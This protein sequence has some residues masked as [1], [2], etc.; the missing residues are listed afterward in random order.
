MI[1][2][3]VDRGKNSKSV[4]GNKTQ[5]FSKKIQ[6]LKQQGYDPVWIHNAIS[7]EEDK[8]H[9]HSFDTHLVILRGTLE[10]QQNGRKVVLQEGDEISIMRDVVH[11][12]RAGESGCRYIVAEKHYD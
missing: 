8:E 9:A 7:C 1:H 12:G 3:I 2:V 11:Y 4:M 5:D 6:E 10:I